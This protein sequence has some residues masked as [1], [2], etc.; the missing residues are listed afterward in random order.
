MEPIEILQFFAQMFGG[1]ILVGL[2]WTLFF[3][4]SGV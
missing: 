3:N 2:V 1:G 4:F